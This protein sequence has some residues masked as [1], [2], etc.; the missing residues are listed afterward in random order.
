MK[1]IVVTGGAGFIGS[2]LVKYLLKKKYFVINI[3][4]L[5]YSANPYNIKDLKKN[6]N[7]VFVK[8]DINNKNKIIKILRKYKPNG[9]F[10]LA[11]ETHVDRSIENAKDFINSNILGTYNLLEAILAFNKKIKLVHVSTDEVYGDVIK[12]RSDEKHPYNPSSPYS[13]SKACS[14]HLINSY[15]RT[16]KLSGVISNCCNNYGQNQFPEKLI[17]KLIFNILNNKNLPIYGRGKNS[18]EWMHV[19]DHCEALLLI[20]LKGKS[21]K[22]YN[23]GSGINLKNIDIAKKLLSIAKNKYIKI[24]KNVKIKYVKDRPGHDLRYALNSKKIFSELGWKS[25]ISLNDGLSET[26]D[27]YWKNKKFFNSVSKKLFVN[28]L[29]LK[30]D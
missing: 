29:G 20:F 8:A 28:R 7:Y 23:I 26:F 17:P 2:N 30:Y 19:K 24:S 13:A 11:A 21:G 14:D 27:W 6:K 5:S 4:K 16:Y 3:D 9:I 15:I 10:N 25:K 22:S 12:G 1:K 18:R